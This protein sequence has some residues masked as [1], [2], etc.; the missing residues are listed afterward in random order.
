MLCWIGCLN[1]QTAGNTIAKKEALAS[2]TEDNRNTDAYNNNTIVETFKVKGQRIVVHR[3]IYCKVY[4][5]PGYQVNMFQ[6]YH[7]V[8]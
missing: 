4:F 1:T 2:F 5:D 8:L 6:C 7:Y 3:I